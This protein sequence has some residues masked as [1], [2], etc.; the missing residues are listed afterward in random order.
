MV[1]K[2]LFV[3]AVLFATT[4]AVADDSK[5][6][7]GFGLNNG[8]GTQ[9]RTYSSVGEYETNY[10]TSSKNIKFG[11]LLQSKD[12]ME[13]SIDTIAADYTDGNSFNLSNT[14]FDKSSEFTGFNLD[15]LLMF[16]GDEKLKPYIDLGF[17][18]Y[19]NKEITG[20]N[21]STGN[22][23]TATGLAL[24]FGVGLVYG[25]TDNFELETSYKMK[26]ISWNLE[27]PDVSEKISMSYI[28]ANF[29]F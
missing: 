10:D 28:G 25:I 9:T 18:I 17:G 19:N 20:I 13:I 14:L 2:S 26:G 23:D 29:K 8:S 21:S 15:Y 1:K 5:Y 3:A 7:V 12:R 6:Y 16:N 22:T 24:N 27:N 4:S 11:F